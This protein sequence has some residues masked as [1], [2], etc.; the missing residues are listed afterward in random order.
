M[1]ALLKSNGV[2]KYATLIG[3]IHHLVNVVFG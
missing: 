3:E 2:M 1:M